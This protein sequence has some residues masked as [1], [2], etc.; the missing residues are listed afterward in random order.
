[1]PQLNS[2]RTRFALWTT[3]LMLGILAIFGTFVYATI[4][5]S[6][7]A[8]LDANLAWSAAQASSSLTVE[9]GRILIPGPAS[10]DEIGRLTYAEDGPTLLVLSGDGSVL[11]ADG[12]YSHV[13]VPPGGSGSAPGF[14]DLRVAGESAPL[15]VYT[16]PVLQ[17]GR[18]AGWVQAIQSLKS[19][20]ATLRQLLLLMVAGGALPSFLA[21]LGGYFLSGHV[22][23]S[24][25]A[26]T[27]AAARISSEDLSARLQIPDAGDEVGR[28]ATTFNGLLARLEHSFQRERQFNADASHELRTPLAAVQSIL[29]VMRQGT[30]S[31]GEYRTALDDL[32]K[33]TGRL[34]SLV[35]DLLRLARGE[36]GSRLHPEPLD[37]AV[38]LAD[39]AG[40]VRPLALTKGL[41]LDCQLP[42]SLPFTGDMDA[43]IRLFVNL[44]DN[45]VKYTRQGGVTLS[46]SCDGEWV[47]VEVADTGIG[48]A[49]EHLPFIF[50]RFYRVEPTRA[51]G[52][53]G[54]GLAIAR[55]LARAAGGRIDV[56]STPGAG[57][58]FTVLFP[59]EQTRFSSN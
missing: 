19:L 3:L 13:A 46:A 4:D 49:A 52:S 30:H 14:S 59:S 34:Q 42:E 56:R 8:S 26:I 45:A 25:D 51:A 41:S 21:G 12:P 43:L 38:L 22:L 53:T 36:S 24:I 33:E 55:Q 29:A 17:N 15:R 32:A 7:R 18:A 54:L 2:L 1:M 58:T 5:R 9:N 40:T 50:E 6:L 57:T 37:L 31:L 23:R 27:R 35:E 48:I 28:L 39:V 16:L 10:Q 11:Q 20:T 47:R 44:L